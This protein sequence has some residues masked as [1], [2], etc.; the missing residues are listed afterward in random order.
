MQNVGQADSCC[1][2]IVWGDCAGSIAR[3]VLLAGQSGR[4]GVVGAT[5]SG[6]TLLSVNFALGTPSRTD[7]SPG[8]RAQRPA[9]RQL[10]S[11]SSELAAST[12][13]RTFRRQPASKLP[14][15]GCR[16]D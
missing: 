13:R 12:S 11:N 16:S 4:S 5:S 9:A 6:A 1:L 10:V 7:D 8:I 3:P 2:Q 15:P 14:H